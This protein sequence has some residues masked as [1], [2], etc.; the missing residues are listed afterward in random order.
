L[1]FSSAFLY[2][3]DI[4]Y[5]RFC[6]SN[7]GLT[8]ANEAGAPV[9][10]VHYFYQVLTQSTSKNSG[11]IK[12]AESNAAT[13]EDLRTFLWAVTRL[14]VIIAYFY[15]CDRTNFFMKESK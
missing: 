2:A 3:L 6:S 15:V 1:I 14:G 9:S 4:F 13:I 7:R 5:R 10:L 11:A 12:S 8:N